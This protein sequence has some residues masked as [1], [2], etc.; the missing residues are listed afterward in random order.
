MIYTCGIFLYDIDKERLLICH[1][2][3]CGKMFSIPKGM[4]DESDS[5]FWNAAIR[6]MKEETNISYT[7]LEIVYSFED[8]PHSLYKSGKKTLV[9]YLIVVKNFKGSNLK[10]IS[11]FKDK[12]GKEIPEIDY[13]KWVTLS[14]A[15]S[16]L[17][18]SQADLL[19]IIQEKIENLS[20]IINM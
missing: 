12:N 13:F 5:S 6:E 16:M 17:P 7:D 3:N 8:L 19:P 1:A 2:T 11:H 9:S 14:S 15:A 10:C 4:K 20:I 18:K